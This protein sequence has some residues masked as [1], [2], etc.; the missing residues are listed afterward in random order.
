MHKTMVILTWFY[1]RLNST[2]SPVLEHWGPQ[3]HSFHE[4]ELNGRYLSL[5][6]LFAN[7]ARREVQSIWGH[8]VDLNLCPSHMNCLAKL[9]NLFKPHF[10]LL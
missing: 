6:G 2:K 4:T 3:N 8:R 9:L 7:T 5:R 10:L 1:I